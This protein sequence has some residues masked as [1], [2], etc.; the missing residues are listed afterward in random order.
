MM[1]TSAQYTEMIGERYYFRVKVPKHITPIC[2]T[3]QIRKSL[4]TS[5]LQ[6]ART[7]ANILHQLVLLLFKQM[8]DGMLS[9]AQMNQLVD[10]CITNM[11]DAQEEAFERR[12]ADNSA[13][14][15]NVPSPLEKVIRVYR[16]SIDIFKQH[17]QANTLL[18]AGDFLE[19]VGEDKKID[20]ETDQERSRIARLF[21]KKMIVT[22]E[23]V[24]I[25]RLN[26]DYTNPYDKDTVTLPKAQ[27]EEPPPGKFPQAL[28]KQVTIASSPKV[29]G[30]LDEYI[31]EKMSGGFWKPN[32]ISDYLSHF[33]LFKECFGDNAINEIKRKD[34]LGYR[35]NILKK[36]PARRN[37]IPRLK[38][39]SLA[40]QLADTRSPK[41]GIKSINGYLGTISSFFTWSLE[42]DYITHN[43]VSRQNVK[44]KRNPHTMRPA[45]SKKEIEKIVIELSKLSQTKINRQ[46]NIDRIWI[47]LIAIYQSFRENEIC[48]LF[49]NDC[50]AI[51]GIPCLIATEALDSEQSIKE[52]ASFRTVPIHKTLIELGFL[53]FVNM[54]R[55][56]RDAII[57]K[58]KIPKA[59]KVKQQQLFITMNCSSKRKNYTKNFLYF[60]TKFNKEI[61]GQPKKSFHSFRHSFITALYNSSKIPYAVSYLAGHSFET[62]TART[63][64][65][66]DLEIL[67]EELSRLDYGFDI[68]KIFGKKALTDKEIAEQVK[69]LS[70]V[71]K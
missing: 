37:I 2:K 7:R 18:P 66:P 31:E 69:H 13:I 62:E 68:F 48:Q 71:E 11:L 39:M 9:K 46:K 15:P 44:E 8:E 58:R 10:E 54:R 35:E 17:L 22:M 1:N 64:T 24:I 21:M 43:P 61:I 34:I 3:I 26:G 52:V 38:K 60:Y 40:Q 63:Y 33:S 23:T 6:T 67:Q 53:D 16:T 20:I 25:P 57:K 28:H 70:V 65:K 56:T 45:Y 42:Q 50:V 5:D 4:K 12:L 30:L 41:I 51:G 19:W 49:I 47:T 14:L 32:T 27:I 29:K 55:T 59:E 36:L